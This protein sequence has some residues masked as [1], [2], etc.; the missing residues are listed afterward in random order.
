MA[1]LLIPLVHSVA[2]AVITIIALLLVAAIIGYLV[3]W[4]YARSV[5]TPVIKGLED[6]KA[7]LLAQVAGLKDDIGKV[8]KEKADLLTQVAGLKDDIG[9]LEKEI[10][11]LKSKMNELEKTLNE[12]ENQIK[13]L[14]KKIKE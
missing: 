8:E 2:G 13:E 3:A 1:Q 5:Y 7:D 6:E 12:K 10:D 9:K 4:F 14:K 11:D